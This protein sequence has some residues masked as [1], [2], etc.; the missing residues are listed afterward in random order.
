MV[1]RC[2]YSLFDGERGG[3]AVL[4]ADGGGRDLHHADG[5]GDSPP[6]LLVARPAGRG[7]SMINELYG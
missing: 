6:A 3:R 2:W 1:L 4:H 5:V 7:E